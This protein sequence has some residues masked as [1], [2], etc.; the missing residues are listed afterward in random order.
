VSLHEQQLITEGTELRFDAFEM[1]EQRAGFLALKLAFRSSTTCIQPQS[2]AGVSS[3][4][5]SL[6]LAAVQSKTPHIWH[7]E[8]IKQ[9]IT[10]VTL[11][12]ANNPGHLS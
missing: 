9:F 11:V 4:E 7:L 12:A 6:Q 2:I 8:C 5:Q 10:V 1:K 3:S